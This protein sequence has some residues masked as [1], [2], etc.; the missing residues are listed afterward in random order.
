MVNIWASWCTGCR[1]EAA[2][3][4]LFAKQHPNVALIGVDSGDSRAGARAAYKRWKWSWPVVFE[5]LSF[6]NIING[7]KKSPI[8]WRIR[9]FE[10]F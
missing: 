10:G 1:L 4:V 8:S 7:R 9:A 6:V 5:G 3:L 2:D